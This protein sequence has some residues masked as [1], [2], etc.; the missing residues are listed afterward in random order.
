MFFSKNSMPSASNFS[1]GGG[2]AGGGSAPR[3]IRTVAADNSNETDRTK[4]VHVVRI[5]FVAIAGP[6]GKENS[7]ESGP[8][9]ITSSPAELPD[10]ATHLCPSARE[11]AVRGSVRAESQ[12]I[13]TQDQ[14]SVRRGTPR[15]VR[16]AIPRS[17]CQASDCSDTGHAHC[18]LGR[19]RFLASVAITGRSYGVAAASPRFCRFQEAPSRRQCDKPRVVCHSKKPS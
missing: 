18:D 17:D 13:S 8:N 7:N 12:G 3:T 15:H 16:V 6:G 2:T 19:G 9:H 14:V 4:I 11:I 5:R 10:K 1:S